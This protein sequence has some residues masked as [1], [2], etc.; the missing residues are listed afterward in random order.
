MRSP[1]THA[2]RRAGAVLAFIALVTAALWVSGTAAAQTTII[3]TVTAIPRGRPQRCRRSTSGVS[4]NAMNSAIATGMSTSCAKYATT[5]VPMMA[6][7]QTARVSF[8]SVP[9]AVSGIG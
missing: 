6:T 4:S 2:S 8:E 9:L 3:T 7:S 5:P 1:T